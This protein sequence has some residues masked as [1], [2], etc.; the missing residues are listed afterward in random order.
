MSALSPELLEKAYTWSWSR[1]DTDPLAKAHI[2]ACFA[3]GPLCDNG[4]MLLLGR[5]WAIGLGEDKKLVDRCD[6]IT[7][8][9]YAY[10]D[11]LAR[12]VLKAMEDSWV[13][14]DADEWRPKTT[15]VKISIQSPDH[16]PEG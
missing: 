11:G 8:H 9:A 15:T 5:V 13:G 12:L 10:R 4:R 16:N 6:K 7:E 3:L 14:T 2:H 1:K